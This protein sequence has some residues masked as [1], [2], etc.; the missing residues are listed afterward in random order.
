ME[1]SRPLPP[2]PF[3]V[4]MFVSKKRKSSK[5]FRG[6]PGNY[7]LNQQW[8]IF[9]DRRTRR[10]RDRSSRTRREIERSSDDE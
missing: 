5:K 9:S 2:G 10:N 3:L 6:T 7:R 1:G 4:E 8:N